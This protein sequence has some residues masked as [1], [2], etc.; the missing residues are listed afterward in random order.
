MFI[1]EQY[2]MFKIKYST[3]DVCATDNTGLDGKRI[4]QIKLM[5]YNATAIATSLNVSRVLTIRYV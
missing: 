3:Y 5:S 1:N 2:V 4:T